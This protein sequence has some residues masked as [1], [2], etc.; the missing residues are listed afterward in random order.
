MEQCLRLDWFVVII[1]G[2]FV[3][4]CCVQ[5]LTHTCAGT[6]GTQTIQANQLLI[7]LQ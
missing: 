7:S 5:V 6:Q 3:Y 4:F 2:S 1:Q